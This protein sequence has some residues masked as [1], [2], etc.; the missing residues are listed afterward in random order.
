M[1][2]TGP[3]GHQEWDERYADAPVWSGAPNGALVAEVASLS[4]GRVLDVGCGEGADAVWLA[5]QGWDVMAIDVSTVA[6]GRGRDAAA[7]AGVEVGWRLA[8]LLDLDPTTVG[9]FDLVSVQYPALRRTPDLAAERV[10]LAA[11]APGGT[12]LVVTHADI[13]RAAALE[14]GFDPEEYVGHE[15]V[16]TAVEAG[17]ADGWVVEADERRERHVEGG[18]GA[19][20]T[21]DVVLR[22]RLTARGLSA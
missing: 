5:Q 7:A 20:H 4:R 22:A 19:H 3:D 2:E 8:G 21:H 1:S 6:L 9:A 11:V 12:L 14:R 13:D 10:L 17:A 18:G 15:Q 16:R